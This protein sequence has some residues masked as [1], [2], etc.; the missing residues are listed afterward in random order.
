MSDETE[1]RAPAAEPPPK[2]KKKKRKASVEGAPSAAP[3]RD[4]LAAPDAVPAFALAFPRDEELDRLVTLFEAGRYDLVR[5]GA[6]EL[7]KKTEDDAVR[8]AA[9]ELERRLDPD[10]LARWLLLGAAALLAFLAFWYWTHPHTAA[11]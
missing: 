10:P 5:R 6:V 1:A 3:E 8:R 9:R 2:K 11:P 7:A 4:E